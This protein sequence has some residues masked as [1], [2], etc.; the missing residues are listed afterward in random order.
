MNISSLSFFF[1]S[2]FFFPFFFLQEYVLFVLHPM[3]NFFSSVFQLLL[4][5]SRQLVL[6]VYECEFFCATHL[7]SWNPALR[8]LELLVWLKSC[9]CWLKLTCKAVKSFILHLPKCSGV[10]SRLPAFCER[11]RWWWSEKSSNVKIDLAFA[12]GWA[13]W[14]AYVCHLSLMWQ[15]VRNHLVHI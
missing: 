12:C 2:F 11:P 7:A 14:S 10:E 13:W 15:G 9:T 8:C 4:W 5:Y 6:W 3:K 1:F